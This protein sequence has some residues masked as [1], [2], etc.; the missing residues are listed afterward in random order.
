MGIIPELFGRHKTFP[1]IISEQHWY[2]SEDEEY[3]VD[4]DFSGVMADMTLL[5]A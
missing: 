1:D 5:P 4:D 3:P 2:Y